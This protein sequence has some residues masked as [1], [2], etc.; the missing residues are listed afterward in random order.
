MA[1]TDTEELLVAAVAGAIVGAGTVYLLSQSQ[2]NVALPAPSQAP[3]GP[4]AFSNTYFPTSTDVTVA[5]GNITIYVDVDTIVI[6]WLPLG[7]K[8]VSVDGAGITN[9]IAPQTFQFLGP[10]THTYVWTDSNNKTQTCTIY[11]QVG[12]STPIE[13]T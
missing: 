12:T 10:I 13:S 5:P 6:V 11:F 2:K 3:Q 8:W 9:T 7:G 4:S 1:A